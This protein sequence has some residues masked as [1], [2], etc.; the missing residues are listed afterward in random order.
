MTIGGGSND[1]DGGRR[2]FVKR[3]LVA[4]TAAT[5]AGN[6]WTIVLSLVAIP[7]LLAGL[8]AEAF[9]IWALLQT[10]SVSTGWLSLADSGIGVAASR[11]IAEAHSTD[12]VEALEETVA[13]SFTL[14]T[15]AGVLAALLL[16]VLGLLV[17]P[18]LFN[19]P[20][21]LV[22]VTKAAAALAGVQALIDL[23]GRSFQTSLEGLQRVD[24]GR[25]A[26]TVRRTVVTVATCAAATATG[27]LV[28]VA[29]AAALSS[30]VG[31]ATAYAL[32]R[33]HARI[34]PRL[35]SFGRARALFRYGLTVALLRPIGVIHRT[36]DRLV[37]GAVLGP[38]A[39]AAVEVATNLVSGADAVL[40]ASSYSVTPA[41]A[42]LAA[43]REDNALRA[44]L[45]RGT[46]LSMAVTMP[47]TVG[48]AVMSAPF[49]TVWLGSDAPA[50]VALFASVGV[51]STLLAA[52]VAIS[53]N[54][55]L[56][57]GSAVAVLKAAI[58]GITVNVALTIALVHAVG[59]VGAFYATIAAGLVTVPLIGA[60]GLSRFDVRLGAFMR[61]SVVPGT[62][63]A[64]VFGIVLV[65][66]RLVLEAPIAELVVGGIVG[67]VVV[68]LMTVAVAMTP[69]ERAR[70]LRRR[71]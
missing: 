22:T 50:D 20:D 71:H 9:G 43:S 26:D 38:S 66:A 61:G 60:A 48:I 23:I 15:I 1:E 63:P 18:S 2:R 19:V 53:S 70:V 13:T 14:F 69:D 25:L 5:A 65:L 11:S 51:I 57:V 8:G 68:A 46:R 12:D 52:P 54:M 10:F 44:L 35:T 33:R 17:L 56:G 32:L 6:V 28:V 4:N 29:A 30:L 34:R 39:V 62:L 59:T 24:L 47:L 7:L 31:V 67:G 55:L 41:A 37:V 58:A 21:S 36:V 42:W 64:F 27:D 49:V 16:A 45:L 3:R 40:S